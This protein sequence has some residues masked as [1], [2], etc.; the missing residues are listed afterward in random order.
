MNT[1]IYKNN[2]VEIISEMQVVYSKVNVPDHINRFFKK[3]EYFSKWLV[4]KGACLPGFD[5]SVPT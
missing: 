3:N 4:V 1:E 2:Q 5:S